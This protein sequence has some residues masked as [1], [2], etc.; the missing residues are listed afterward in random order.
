M[1]L[2][3][4]INVE[5]F[6]TEYWQKKPLLIRNAWPEFQPLL[7]SQELAGLSLEEEIESRLIQEH[8]E[9]PWQVKNGPFTEEDYQHL[10]SSHWTLL[11][12][13]V[14]QWLP[15]A[16][17]LLEKFRFLPSWRI[18]DLM[19]SYATDQGSVGPHY[20]H[21]D[22]FLLQ[23]EGQREWRIGQSCD[24]FDA[25]MQGPRIRILEN[26]EE[27]HRW[28]LNPGDMLYLPAGVA[29]WGIAQGECQT[30]S[31]GF[32][33]PSLAELTLACGNDFLA[34]L[35]ED[36]RYQDAGLSPRAH[37]GL[38]TPEAIAQ[39][40]H[41]LHKALG[42]DR[43]LYR[44]LGSLMT[45]AKYPELLPDSKERIQWNTLESLLKNQPYWRKAEFAR[46]AYSVETSC[47]H[48][49]A[50]GM[51]RPFS[52]QQ[53]PLLQYLSGQNGYL[54]DELMN[55]AN[56]EEGQELLLQLW[57]RHAIYCPDLEEELI[58]EDEH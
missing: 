29:H 56:D 51:S 33:A 31:I 14:D 52:M 44:V 17:D 49:Y 25:I 40:R 42:D 1:H 12:Q 2:L 39:M 53:L 3:G 58:D 32:R 10:P 30:Y 15:E 50:L 8:G 19:I 27:T 37:S 6:L 7:S 48:F 47:C 21:Y 36:K 57:Q 28:I 4:E 20:D 22:V 45:E 16:A 23:A 24:E 43:R 54:A 18:D 11:V 34:S 9:T 5:R 38:I 55:L 13:A 26:F 35:G 46:F 41:L